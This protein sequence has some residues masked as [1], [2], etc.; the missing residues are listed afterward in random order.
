MHIFKEIEPLKAFLN[1]KKV[2]QRSIG[3]VPTMGAL[4]AGHLR[5]VQTSKVENQVTVSSIYVTLHSSI[6]LVTSRN[7]PGH[8]RRT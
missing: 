7:I 2:Q 5:L 1:Q 6:I 4:L 3:L 8:W